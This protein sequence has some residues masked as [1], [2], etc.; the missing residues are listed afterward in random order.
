MTRTIAAVTAAA[1]LML[2]AGCGHRLETMALTAAHDQAVASTQ[3]TC[4]QVQNDSLSNVRRGLVYRHDGQAFNPPAEALFANYHY[5]CGSTA[6][7]AR[8]QTTALFVYIDP[9]TQAIYTR[10]GDS[11]AP[12]GTVLAGFN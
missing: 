7:Q 10:L 3:P 8:M 6:A 11:S 5:T 1:G 2:L 12:A 4:A 9:R